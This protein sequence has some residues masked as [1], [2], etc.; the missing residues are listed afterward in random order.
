MKKTKKNKNPTTINDIAKELDLNISTVSRALKDH[1]KISDA[2]KEQVLKTAKQLNYSPN[3]IAAA[4][5]KGKSNVVGVMVPSIDEAF[6]AS[7]IHGIE[8][9]LKKNGYRV[10]ISQSDDATE[11]EK[12]NITTMLEAK[13]DGI[14]AS[15]A[16]QTTS[17]DHYQHILDKGIPLIMFDRFNEALDA[18]VVANDDFKGAYRAVEH[19]I[20]QGCKTIAHIGGKSNVHIYR[21]RLKGYKKALADYDLSFNDKL[22]FQTDLK[23]NTGRKIMEKIIQNKSL[24]DAIFAANDH[25]AT[26]AIQVLL[27]HNIKVPE[28]VAIVGYSNEFFSSF[29]TPSLTSVDQHSAQIGEAA[30]KLLLDQLNEEDDT[31]NIPQKTI[32]SPKLIIRESSLKEE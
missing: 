30:A 26:G 27:E 12:D 23:L 28:Q 15:H 7:A 31:I 21:E 22:T 9:T 14:L 8:K 32:L 11:N 13:V 19:L 24:P 29:V 16:M 6:F 4:L 1:P 17:F 10:I 5:A 3:H 18:H 25:S 2:T 20:K